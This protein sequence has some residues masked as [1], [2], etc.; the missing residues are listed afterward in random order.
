MK[1]HKGK[2]VQKHYSLL[3]QVLTYRK[4]PNIKP[5]LIT[6]GLYHCYDIFLLYFQ[7]IEINTL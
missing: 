7:P 1:R 6:E 4:I 5:G 3:V 2:Q